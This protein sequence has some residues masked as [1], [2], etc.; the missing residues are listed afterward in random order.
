LELRRVCS[1]A[2]VSDAPLFAIDLESIRKGNAMQPVDQAAPK[3]D[4]PRAGETGAPTAAFDGD[5]ATDPS[6]P[7]GTID[8]APAVS[9]AAVAS[10]QAGT[11]DH[12]PGEAAG[13]APQRGKRISIPGYELLGVLGRGGMGVVYQARQVKADRVV[14]V[15]LMLHADHADGA[16][17]DRFDTEAQAVARLQHPNIVQVFEVGE[18]DGSPFFS[19]EFVPGGSLSKRI[20][21]SML[22]A[23][24]AA[25][26]VG[27]LARAMAYAHRAGILHRDLKPDN[28]LLTGQGEPKIADF[29]LARKLEADSRVTQAGHLFGTP[30]YMPPEQTS[31]ELDAVG[32]AA[33]IYSLGAILYELLTGRPPFVGANLWET[34]AQVRD[35]EPVPPHVLRPATP[36]DLE[37]ICLKCLRKDV[38][39]RYAS[40]DALAED[41]Q[42]YLDGVP[43][44]ARPTG[45]DERV[46]RWCRR[47]PWPTALMTTLALA[48]AASIWAA[49]YISEQGQVSRK[50]L[51]VYR[52]SVN[53]FANEIP[54]LGDNVPLAG[55]FRR[56]VI[57]LVSRMFGDAQGKADDAA[58][59]DNGLI[60]VELRKADLAGARGDADAAR[61]ALNAARELAEQAREKNPDQRDKA[62]GNLATILA[63]LAR[64]NPREAVALLE[65]AVALRRQVADAPASGEISPTKAR[66]ELGRTLVRLGEAL[67]F[68]NRPD[69][70]LARIDDGIALLAQ[71]DEAGLDPRQAARLRRDHALAV[72]DRARAL[73]QLKRADDARAAYLQACNLLR[74]LVDPVS[75]SVTAR[76]NLAA[77]SAE[78]GDWLM[79]ELNRPVEALAIYKQAQDQYRAVLGNPDVV[80]LQ[81]TGEA[82]GYYRLGAAASRAGLPKDAL[83]H[84]LRCL[85]LREK[86][87]RDLEEVP[88]FPDRGKDLEKDKLR[89]TARRW[90]IVNA[91]IERMLAQSRCGMH[92]EASVTAGNM[93]LLAARPESLKFRAKLLLQGACGFALCSAA[94][95]PG[96]DLQKQ[97]VARSLEAVRLYLGVPGHDLHFLE[98]D[99]DLDPVRP[100]P[101]YQTLLASRKP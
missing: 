57:D 16:S 90:A 34:I 83:A 77:V 59:T 40:A 61:A 74:A 14:A 33:D 86:Q 37:T 88:D 8:H 100:L 36:L 54:T 46:A 25:Q 47:N 41:L 13:K 82:F 64:R 5:T 89:D 43:I 96:S 35:A 28:V 31:G 73:R 22:P 49:A 60:A 84:F 44:L 42:R 6:S 63:E 30:S 11:V 9:A 70:G 76:L 3:A 1:P 94:V 99:P 95:P 101:E 26:L 51:E 62:T 2:E 4:E 20:K 85:A 12:V 27:T 53:T 98:T 24:E 23:R 48:L 21:E 56:D 18:V 97:Y 92:A 65:Q 68:A 32:P 39:Q 72:A 58:A 29:G 66:G 45:P 10:P 75:P 93:L 55:E 79:V 7:D 19:L 87:V 17:R 69:D 50:R 15:K 78:T 52:D 80:A 91:K 67:R 71:A 38:A 81:Q